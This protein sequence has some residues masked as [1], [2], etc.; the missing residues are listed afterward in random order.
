MLTYCANC[1]MPDSKPDLQL[2]AH[3]VC[4]AC[5]AYEDRKVVD[6]GAR[7]QDLLTVL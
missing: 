5:R 6:W 1:V 2:D 3:G 7:Y 4:N